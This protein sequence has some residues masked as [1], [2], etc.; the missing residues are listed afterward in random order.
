MDC[1]LPLIGTI[2][3][4]TA[5]FVSDHLVYQ[6]RK[7]NKDKKGKKGLMST[8][9]TAP[10]QFRQTINDVIAGISVSFDERADR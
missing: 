3:K 7:K 6:E 8:F 9:H 1:G 2:K 5:C 10:A 4:A